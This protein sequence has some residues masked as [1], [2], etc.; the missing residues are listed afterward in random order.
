[1]S[2]IY[3]IHN[4]GARPFKVVIE[5]NNV[6]VFKIYESEYLYKS[7]PELD[8]SVE[9]IFVPEKEDDDTGNTILLKTGVNQYIFIGCDISS[10]SS[11]DEIVRYESPIMGSDVPYP[12]AIDKSN[13]IY[14]LIEKVIMTNIHELYPHIS[15]I[16]HSHKFDPYKFYYRVSIISKL[17]SG[18]RCKYISN[19]E[20][21]SMT[22]EGNPLDSYDD[23]SEEYEIKYDPFPIQNYKWL[24]GKNGKMLINRTDGTQI[25]YSESEYVKLMEDVGRKR[26]FIPLYIC[27]LGG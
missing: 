20:I 8:I 7:E 26:G 4:N 9:Q 5:G 16:L 2:E 22:I 25:E 27:E 17:H 24:V 23:D 6:K 15:D 21:Y 14:L 12:Y 3:Y 1:M 19:N 11:L 10:F 18:Q 13:N